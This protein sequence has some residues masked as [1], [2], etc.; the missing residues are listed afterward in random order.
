[1]KYGEYN[2]GDL[3]HESHILGSFGYPR[4]WGYHCEYAGAPVPE[5]LWIVPRG[6]P[7]PP[8]VA[9]FQRSCV[10]PLPDPKVFLVV[11]WNTGRRADDEPELHRVHWPE[12]G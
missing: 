8:P 10:V 4:P 2:F 12:P 6:I 9:R 1:M 11:E 3:T 7:A 5:Q